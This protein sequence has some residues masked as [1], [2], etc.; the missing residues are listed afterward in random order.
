ME[1]LHVI[2]EEALPPYP[3]S[4]RSTP[5]TVSA[6]SPANEMINKF[7]KGRFGQWCRA[8]HA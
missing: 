1:V 4:T 7:K 5:T 8:L 3:T 2:G 6:S